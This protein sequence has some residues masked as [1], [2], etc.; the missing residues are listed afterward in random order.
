MGY[1]IDTKN[2]YS[3]IALA[4]ITDG[5]IDGYL[6]LTHNDFDITHGVLTAEF[7]EVEFELILKIYGHVK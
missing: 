2:P 4:T 5:I 6:H 1:L 7:T 3:G